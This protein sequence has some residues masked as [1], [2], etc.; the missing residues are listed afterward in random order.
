MQI[1]DVYA[2]LRKENKDVMM[3]TCQFLF[4]MVKNTLLQQESFI[5]AIQTLRIKLL[6]PGYIRLYQGA[7][8]RLFKW[9]FTSGDT[10][11]NKKIGTPW[12]K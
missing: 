8:K 1:S 2:Q 7:L 9:E 11:M 4:F 3:Q 5:K 6:C 10:R 12:P